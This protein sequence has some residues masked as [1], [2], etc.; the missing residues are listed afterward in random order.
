MLVHH[1]GLLG[2]KAR[3]RAYAA[4]AKAIG[5]PHIPAR[6]EILVH[7]LAASSE[8]TSRAALAAESNERAGRAGPNALGDEMVR[9]PRHGPVLQARISAV[10]RQC[11]RLLKAAEATWG[12]EASLSS[13]DP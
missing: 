4:A 3:E 1:A 11:Q 13:L 5:L 10:E 8:E 6:G 12:G 2:P 9:P 7:L